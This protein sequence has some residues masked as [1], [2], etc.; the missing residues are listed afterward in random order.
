MLIQAPNGIL[1]KYQWRFWETLNQ[2]SFRAK[3]NRIVVSANFKPFSKYNERRT[4]LRLI[5]VWRPLL[6]STHWQSSLIIDEVCNSRAEN[7][8]F[9]R[10]RERGQL[11]ANAAC[12]C[13]V[14]RLMQRSSVAYQTYA[15]SDYR[16]CAGLRC[17]CV[18]IVEAI[19]ILLNVLCFDS[20]ACLRMYHITAVSV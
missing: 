10:N 9:A 4:S 11:L 15:D 19:S 12:T 3:F 18:C 8:S 2:Q 6:H 17:V 7:L 20:S 16:N 1:S 13:Q 5:R 14:H